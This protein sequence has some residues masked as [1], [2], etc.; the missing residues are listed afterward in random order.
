MA[1]Y[2]KAPKCSKCGEEINGKYWQPEVF[3]CGDTFTGWDWAGHRCRL[4]TKYFIERTDDHRW[5]WDNGE[6]TQ[7]ERTIGFTNNP[8]TAK[9]FDSKEEADIF[10]KEKLP[11]FRFDLE[12]TEHLFA[13]TD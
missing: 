8:M 12:V 7:N 13:S 4:G 9:M 6:K 2:R 10:L 3:F 11:V 1:V 5:Y